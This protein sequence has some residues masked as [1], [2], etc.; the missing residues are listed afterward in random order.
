MKE[1]LPES[2]DDL[3]GQI[4]E[5]RCALIGLINNSFEINAKIDKLSA[6]LND[7]EISQKQTDERLNAVIMMAERF[8]SGENGDFSNKK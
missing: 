8:F 2:P 3:P 5:L 7:L 6:R 1:I 4:T